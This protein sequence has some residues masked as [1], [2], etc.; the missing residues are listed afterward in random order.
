MKTKIRNAGI[1]VSLCAILGGPLCGCAETAEHRSTGQY[2]DDAALTTKVKAK[3]L[4]DSLTEGLKVDVDTYEGT[5]QL[6]GFVDSERERAR[7]SEL[8]QGVAGVKLVRNDLI[9]R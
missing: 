8:A 3:L 5:V 1:A 7:A 2:I 6:S 4:E 9:V